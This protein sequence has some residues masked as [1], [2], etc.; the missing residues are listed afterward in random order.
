MD[1]ERHSRSH[2]D[3]RDRDS[4]VDHSPERD[5][6]RRHRDGDSKRRDSDHYR[7]SRRDDRDDERDSRGKDRARDSRR[8]VERSDR[9]GSRDREKH[10]HHEKESRSK[11]KERDDEN[12]G[13]EGKKKS[14]F[15]DGNGEKRSRFEDVAMESESQK[16]EVT[17]GFGAIPIGVSTYSSVGL[18]TSM[19]P[20][21]TLLTKVS[22]IS[23]TD[24]NKGVSIVRSH[25]VHGKSSTDGTMAGKTSG[26]LSLDAVAKA[27]RAIQMGKGLADK[28]KNL[29]SLN[30]SSKSSTTITPPV[31]AGTSSGS[32]QLNAGLFG[33]GGIDNIEA[34][35]KVKRAQEVAANMGFRQDP[36]FAPII[37]LFPGLATTDTAVAQKPTKTPVLRVDALGREIDE[38]G[39]VI[40]VTKPSNLSTLKVNINKQKKDA[41]QILKPQLEVDPDENP[42]YDPRMGIDK[43]KI[44]RPKRM[45]FQFVEE[46]KWTRDAESLKLKSQF[47]EAKARELKVKQAHLA[48]A[49]DDINPNFI[50]VSERFP[51]KEKPKEQIPDVEWWDA[52]I[53]TSGV[54][55]DIAD[56]TVAES[57]LKIEK[58]THYVEHPRPIEPPAEAAPPPP[59]PLKLTAR[60]R[61]KLRT[62]RRLAKEKEKQE[63]IRQGLLE[64]PKGKV[65]MSNLMKVLG[66]EATQDPTKLEKEI[67]TA[68]AEREQAHTDRNAAR[69]LT[70]A[71]KSQ[72]KERKLFDD[73]TTVETLVSVYKINNKLSHPKIKFKVEMNARQNKLTGCSVTSEEMSVVVVEGKSKAIKRY[74]KVMLKRIN[75]EDAVKDEENDEDDE[76]EDEKKERNK[77]WLVWQGSVAKPSFHRFV[78][79]DCLTE[80]AAKKVF[81][82]AG[83]THY[84]DL[85]LN[86]TDD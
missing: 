71:E 27:K 39:N 36:E 17:Q 83:V 37:N 15:S 10:H 84:W 50:E 57:H 33:L 18:E 79:Q 86:Y 40:S 5:G 81:T 69:K 54:Y 43:T 67:R 72:K 53:L 29:P 12:G 80:S 70:P 31:S 19:A 56:E 74:G 4:S 41:F 35:K 8:S 64:P 51:R 32:V 6:G 23:T 14:R 42:H 60:E 85:A 20:S 21:Q 3:D 25:E 44:L 38:H 59:Q 11:R 7:S 46:G 28:L 24:E 48:K 76:E 61:K 34:V 26:N 1:K 22:S 49:K 47:G 75:W 45:S 2:R 68:A 9:E 65:K 62:Q 13:K 78:V 82:D 73:P 66:A 63:M 58:L 30:K 16:T 52:S 55:G 77:C